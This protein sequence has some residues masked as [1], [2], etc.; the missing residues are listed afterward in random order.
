LCGVQHQSTSLAT[1]VCVCVCGA[2]SSSQR[3]VRSHFCGEAPA[4]GVNGTRSSLETPPPGFNLRYQ[5]TTSKESYSLSRE[6]FGSG[7]CVQPGNAAGDR[8]KIRALFDS[9]KQSRDL[10][11]SYQSL[12]IGEISRGLFLN[13]QR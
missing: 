9:N 7:G 5:I 4:S 12:F 1:G 2:S 11:F 13:G 3:F 6:T 8:R 10:H